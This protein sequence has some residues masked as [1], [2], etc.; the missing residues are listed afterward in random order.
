VVDF[1][2]I[3]W[4]ILATPHLHQEDAAM[5]SYLALKTIHMSAAYLTLTLFALRLALD[6]AGRPGWRRT[7]LR[8]IPHVNDT[9]LL[10]AAISLLFVSGWLPF[11][12]HWLTAKIIFLI[13]YIL[14]GVVALKPGLNRKTRMLAAALAL[15]QVMAIFYLAIRKPGLF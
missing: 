15:L 10:S 5:T 1:R 11:V 14:A 7:P 4:G 9:L 8:W 13:G 12:H 3:L 6:A 2:V